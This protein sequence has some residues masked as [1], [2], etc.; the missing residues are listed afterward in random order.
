MVKHFIRAG[1]LIC[2]FFA[3]LFTVSYFYNLESTG[4]T[5]QMGSATLPVIR[6]SVDG[7]QINLMRGYAEG[8]EPQTMRD[9]VTPLEKDRSLNIVVTKNGQDIKEVSYKVRSLDASNLI[10]D[11]VVKK[12]S[13]DAN[14]LKATLKPKNLLE[15]DREYVLIV[16]LTMKSGTTY[17]YF[18]RI[19]Q[20]EDFHTKEKLEFVENFHKLT[21]KKEDAKSIVKNLESD[22]SGDNQHFQKVNIHSSFD[23]VT[24]G[25]LEI[26]VVGKEEYSVVDQDEEVGAVLID[27]IAQ[28]PN[29]EGEMEN[30]KVQEYYRVR[31][32]SSRMYLLDFERTMEQFFQPTNHVFHEKSIDLGVMREDLEY[33]TNEEGNQIAFVTGGELWSYDQDND[34][35]YQ[36][37]SFLGQEYTDVRTNKQNHNV[38]VL[39]VDKN[40]D[41]DFLVY[42][43]MSRGLR[44][45]EVG[46]AVYRFSKS[47]NCIEEVC[48]IPSTESVHFLQD[49][50]GQIAYINEKS[51]LFL[52]LEGTVYDIDLKEKE[53]AVL[54]E[55]L[56]DG[57]FAISENGSRIAWQEGS[58]MYD[59]TKI[60]IV[61][62][63]TKDQFVLEA[64][65]DER[66]LPVGFLKED[67]IYGAARVP[68]IAAGSQA[69]LFPM[70]K[71]CVL[72]K[73]NQLQREYGPAGIYI[74]KAS[75]EGNVINMERMK[76]GE[77]GFEETAPDHMVNNEVEETSPVTLK[78]AKTDL[79]KT[80]LSLRLVKEIREQEPTLMTPKQ[81]IYEE[82]REITLERTKDNSRFYV[83]CKGK[84]LGIY[85]NVLEAINS[86]DENAGV[87]LNSRMNYVWER[88]N[89]KEKVKLMEI[90][91]TSMP[92]GA[93]SLNVAMNMIFQIE[94]KTSANADTLLQPGISI[95][96]AMSQGLQTAQVY[97]LSG[98]PLKTALYYVNRNYPVLARMEG[99]KYCLIVGYDK[100][101]TI[102]MDPSLGEVYYYGINDSTKLFE[103]AGNVFYAYMPN[104]IIVEE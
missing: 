21:F 45:G 25:D 104:Q 10:E 2:V 50:V 73:A 34:R 58:K 65:A 15:E 67:F 51:E 5:Q 17:D 47:K 33:T 59:T 83:F 22:S 28:A 68:D 14:E 41:M 101:N 93:N 63:D 32:T 103:E 76:I 31:Y 36:V 80:V 13:E 66:I 82:N 84:I 81:V 29:G 16:S 102:L 46:I 71:I 57:T 88:A 7:K 62:L 52:M 97:N 48:F 60:N 64:G 44:E 12:V 20:N 70:Y 27:Y 85:G 19:I 30:Y 56:T 89:R 92:T 26:Q 53:V 87:V 96:G 98:G 9:A 95:E 72:D 18:T 74:T 79:K 94:G 86:A 38:K 75:V 55:G 49:D 1:V 77:D 90:G 99:D 11:T 54:A 24:F 37:F 69:G 4:L 43:Y 61:N 91:P 78:T 100:Y 8:L 6:A 35:L 40:G 39:T 23:A 3:A 42:G